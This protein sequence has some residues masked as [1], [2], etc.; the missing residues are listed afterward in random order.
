[1]PRYDY[2][3]MQNQRK[4][5]VE[6]PMRVYLQNWGELC[7]CAEIEPGETPLE[8]PVERLISGFNIYSKGKAGRSAPTAFTGPAKAGCGAGCMC[9]G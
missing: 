8:T 2:F 9:C 5:E 7:D 1:M 6:H 3:C 4:V